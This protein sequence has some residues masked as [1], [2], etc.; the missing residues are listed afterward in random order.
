MELAAPWPAGAGHE[1]PAPN[2]LAGRPADATTAAA[3]ALPKE[4]DVIVIAPADT[5]AASSTP[6]VQGLVISGG[7]A[8]AACAVDASA[9]ARTCQAP[10]A[11]HAADAINAAL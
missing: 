7:D 3:S 11:R 6:D 4:H 10:V 5:A 8:A 1:L 2:E 9:A